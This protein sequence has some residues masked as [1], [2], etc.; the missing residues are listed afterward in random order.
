MLLFQVF[1]GSVLLAQSG[2]DIKVNIKPFRKQYIYLGY[3]YGKRKALADSVLLDLNSSGEFKGKKA[4]G[5]GIYFIVSPQKQIL[6]EL[7]IDK[8]QNFSITADTT[9]LPSSIRFMGSTDN[10]IFQSYTLRLN[11]VGRKSMTCKI[12]FQISDQKQ[13]EPVQQ[14]IQKLNLRFCNTGIAWKKISE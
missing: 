7:L 2:Y 1:L 8:Q 9:N 10:F 4:L 13:K 12:W 14:R 3:H 6:F 5:G 11:K